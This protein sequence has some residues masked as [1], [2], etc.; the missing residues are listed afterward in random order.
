MQINP[1]FADI[2]DSYHQLAFQLCILQG[3]SMTNQKTLTYK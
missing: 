1:G 2:S 3:I